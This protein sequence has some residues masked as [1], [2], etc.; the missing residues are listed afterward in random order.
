MAYDFHPNVGLMV[1]GGNQISTTRDKV[2]RS[3][4]FGGTFQEFGTYPG[5]RR[6]MYCLVII[7]E[8][9]IFGAGGHCKK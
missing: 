9:T 7:D 8:N 5:G 6:I 3:M 2:E 4:D 1:A